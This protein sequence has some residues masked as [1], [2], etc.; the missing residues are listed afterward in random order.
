[1]AC[2]AGRLILRLEVFPAR[3]TLGPVLAAQ[4][5]LVARF[6]GDESIVA[7]VAVP[8]A[9]PQVWHLVEARQGGA[10]ASAIWIAGGAASGGLRSRLRQAWISLAG[11][12][13][14]P[15]VAAIIGVQPDAAALIR[16]FLADHPTLSARMARL[17]AVTA[18]PPG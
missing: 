11:S 5:H 9:V 15:V 10:A 17:S 4:R 12:D 3:V 18:R 2:D 7:P 16:V 6:A 1:F 8:G 13:E 14:A